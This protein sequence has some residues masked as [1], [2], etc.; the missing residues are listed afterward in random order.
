VVKSVKYWV[1]PVTVVA[2][3]SWTA[4]GEEA[5]GHPVQVRR[6]LLEVAGPAGAGPKAAAVVG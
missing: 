4:L 6:C 3:R 5:S 1:S 2:V